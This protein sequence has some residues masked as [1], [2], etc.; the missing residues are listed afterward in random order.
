MLKLRRSGKTIS[1]AL[2]KHLTA[3][4][5]PLLMQKPTAKEQRNAGMLVPV[6]SKIE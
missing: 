5:C 2:P 4:L 6:G 3:L 1:E